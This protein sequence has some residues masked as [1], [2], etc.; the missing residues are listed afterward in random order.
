LKDVEKWAVLVNELF[1]SVIGSISVQ[2]SNISKKR[3]KLIIGQELFLLKKIL[4]KF[5]QNQSY[6]IDDINVALE[7]DIF[8]ILRSSTDI[9]IQALDILEK[10]AFL[11]GSF[12]KEVGIYQSQEKYQ[13]KTMSHNQLDQVACK[14]LISIDK[15]SIV[16]AHVYNTGKCP[17]CLSP[18]R[19]DEFMTVKLQNELKGGLTLG[20]IDENELVSVH[21]TRSPD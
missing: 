12:I 16:M 1:P 3:I 21:V 11:E 15:T 17:F 18:V 9:L 2:G 6:S 5:P 14:G 7:S 19:V 4:D 20:K 10:H 8:S 13:K